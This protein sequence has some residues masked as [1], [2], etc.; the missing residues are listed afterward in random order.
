MKYLV[1]IILTILTFP[2]AGQEIVKII[3]TSQQADEPP[4][5]QGRPKYTMEFNRQASG[6]FMASDVSVGKKKKK[7]ENRATI[8]SERI[9]KI[10]AWRNLNKVT[11]SQSDLGLETAT[12]KSKTNKYK[13]TFD[14]PSDLVVKIDS[15]QFCQMYQMTSTISTGGETFAVTLIEKGGQMQEIVFNSNDIGKK[16]FN[17]RDYIL[18]YTL[19]ADNI[20]N[21]VPSY[22]FFSKETFI[23][24]ILYY[25]KT[26][27]CEGFYYKEFTD[28]NPEMTARDKRMMQGWDFAEYLRQRN[29]KD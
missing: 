6:E 14:I 27:E 21:E 2:S 26:V 28:K 20:P 8:D 1:L 18:S 22:G 29:K 23:D 13:L 4:T 25:Q 10:T 15:F 5:I 9:K 16:T 24:I 19:F 11:F 17:L 7:L 12:L 3:F